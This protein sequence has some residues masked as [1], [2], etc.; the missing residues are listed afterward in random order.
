MYSSGPLSPSESP[1][2]SNNDAI[3]D[4]W[5]V[6]SSS[7][8]NNAASGLPTSTS[9]LVDADDTDER[10]AFGGKPFSPPTFAAEPSYPTKN[11][12]IN[13]FGGADLVGAGRSAAAAGVGSSSGG[14]GSTPSVE[15]DG[16]R[17]YLFSQPGERTESVRR[18]EEASYHYRPPT[19]SNTPSF[20]N[21]DGGFRA[22]QPSPPSQQSRYQQQQQQQQSQQQLPSGRLGAGP[23]PGSGFAPRAFNSHNP[24]SLLPE[25]HGDQQQQAPVDSQRQLTPGYPMPQG[26]AGGNTGYSPF[27]RVDSLAS[28]REQPEDMYGVPENFLEVEVRNPMTHGYGRKM[29]TDYEIVT[30]VSR[31]VASS[32]SRVQR[33]ELTTASSSLRQTNI[34]AFRFRYSTV[35]RRYSDFE[36][37]RDILERETTRVNIPA[38]PGKVFTNRFTDEVIESRREGLERFITGV[39]SHPLLQVSIFTSGAVTRFDKLTNSSLPSLTLDGKQGSM[40]IPTRSCIHEGS[41]D[42][43]SLFALQIHCEMSS[44]GLSPPYH[45]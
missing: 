40:C 30:R 13:G 26:M 15:E 38:L 5:R 22:R 34:P 10:A 23:T 1:W 43:M 20:G 16:R 41:V 29:Y 18:D 6:P 2:G 45:R 35:R 27:A 28:R 17:S 44:H 37:F 32:E 42:L 11:S 36:Y 33:P 8:T 19:F 3:D 12:S 7:S 31:I 14:W 21:D 25:R 9:S 24:S 4:P 39:A